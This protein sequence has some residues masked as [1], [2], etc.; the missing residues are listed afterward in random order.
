MHLVK[1]KFFLFVILVSIYMCSVQLF[2]VTYNES[3]FG[4]AVEAVVSD[5]TSYNYNSH[6][7][8]FQT[9]PNIVTFCFLE[10]CCNVNSIYNSVSIEYDNLLVLEAIHDIGVERLMLYNY[11]CTG[12]RKNL[13]TEADMETANI[14]VESAS[15][16]DADWES[17]VSWMKIVSV[18]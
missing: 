8:I 14:A 11:L 1:F 6:F 10:S 5:V 3:P 18:Q 12:E 16:N 2:K 13:L 4:T 9:Y 15:Q 7:D 17:F